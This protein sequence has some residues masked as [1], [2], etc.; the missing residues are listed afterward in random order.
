MMNFPCT[1][2]TAISQTETFRA[3][4][5]SAKALWLNLFFLCY[6]LSSHLW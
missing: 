3:N 6:N 4:A 1:P 2:S 5:V